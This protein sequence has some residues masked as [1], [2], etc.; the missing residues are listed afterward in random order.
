[1]AADLRKCCSKD[2]LTIDYRG[3][4]RRGIG[5]GS[6]HA[7]LYVNVNVEKMAASSKSAPESH[8]TSSTSSAAFAT[9]IT[10]F[11]YIMFLCTRMQL[12]YLRVPG[13]EISAV[14]QF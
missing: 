11:F 5:N 1:M 12:L 2:N 6:G 7:P 10:V 14:L 4:K 3:A 9:D 13:H 8:V